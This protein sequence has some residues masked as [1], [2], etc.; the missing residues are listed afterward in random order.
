M[1][2]E[3]RKTKILEAALHIFAQKGFQDTTIAEISKKA[4]VSEPTVY[5]YFKTK[6]DL[7]FAIPEKITEEAISSS[8]MI[9][10]YINGTENKIR[11]MVYGL[12]SLF[13][14]NPDYSA[15]FLLQ[16]KNNRKFSQTKAYEKVK[17]VTG[18]LLGYI[19]EGIDSGLFRNDLNPYLIRSMLLGTIE[20]VCTR[21]H[22][23]GKPSDFDQYTDQ[24]MDL[25]LRGIKKDEGVRDISINLHL[26]KD[27]KSFDKE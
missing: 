6:E 22:L 18:Q 16:L 10:G 7:F 13:K 19:K 23:L 2:K 25:I 14:K 27:E 24:I 26:K 8:S 9:M 4:G 12:L 11:A 15:L 5:E 1:T 17:Y 20:H 21:W 3:N